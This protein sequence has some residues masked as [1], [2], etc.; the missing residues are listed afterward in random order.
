MSKIGKMPINI[1]DASVEVKGNTV[2][3]KG[4]HSEGSHQVPDFLTITL[5]DKLLKIDMPHLQKFRKKDWGLHRALLANKIAGANK[6]FEKKVQ[7]IGLGYKV[8]LGGSKMTFSLGYSHKIELELPKT[9]SLNVDKSGQNLTFS[10]PDKELL[11]KTCDS[12]RSLRPPEP[13]KGTGIK[14]E[15]EVIRRKAGKTKS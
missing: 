5:D 7:I 15:D 8:Q 14:L 1:G 12:V 13:Y 6:P 11:G 9:V 2:F 3:Y 10:C 4:K